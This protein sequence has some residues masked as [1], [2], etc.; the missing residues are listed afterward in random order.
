MA[1][2]ALVGVA[3]Q[4]PGCLG[5]LVAA[6]S[7]DSLLQFRYQSGDKRRQF[8]VL[9]CMHQWPHLGVHLAKLVDTLAGQGFWR[10][11][12]NRLDRGVAGQ[13]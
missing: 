1:A 2:T 6:A 7:S 9:T 4:L 13:R 5:Q 3:Q 10:V 11:A 12:Q 8:A